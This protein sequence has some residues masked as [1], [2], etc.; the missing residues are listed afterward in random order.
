MS[1]SGIRDAIKTA[2]ETISGL[3]AYDTVPDVIDPPCAWVLPKAGDYHKTFSSV[4]LDHHFEVTVLLSRA[5]HIALGQDAADVYL[6]PSGASSL[7]AAIEAATLSTHAS[8]I[9][10]TGYK[11][12]GGFE[13]GGQTY[14]GFKLD[15]EVLVD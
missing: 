10:V 4:T 9:V 3:N 11:D 13:F 14:I 8:D 2:L 12:Y 7:I 5:G 6:D 15:V 1:L